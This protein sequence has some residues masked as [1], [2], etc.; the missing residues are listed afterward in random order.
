M[1]EVMWSLMV[2]YAGSSC[3]VDTAKP[4]PRHRVSSLVIRSAELPNISHVAVD[5]VV[6][7][8]GPLHIHNSFWYSDLSIWIG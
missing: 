8:L 5:G 7:C 6:G 4:M 2:V 1:V 3:W